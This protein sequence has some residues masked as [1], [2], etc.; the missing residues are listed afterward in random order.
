MN[1]ILARATDAI[2]G[3]ILRS[4]NRLSGVSFS[5]GT[6]GQHAPV[7]RGRFRSTVTDVMDGGRRTSIF[8]N[9]SPS[10]SHQTGALLDPVIAITCP[11]RIQIDTDVRRHVPRNSL[12]IEN[13][14]SLSRF[15]RI[16]R[17]TETGKVTVSQR[18]YIVR[19][20]RCVVLTCDVFGNILRHTSP[21]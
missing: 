7:L 17:S 20:I 6:D 21:R 5:N 16:R 3:G 14:R 1:R 4:Y 2:I 12:V 15:G 9:V 11:S 18:L 19:A 8:T 13:S 10:L